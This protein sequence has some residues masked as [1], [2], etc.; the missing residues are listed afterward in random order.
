MGYVSTTPSQ[1]RDAC[2]QS[3]KRCRQ[4]VDSDETPKVTNHEQSESISE[5]HQTLHVETR[6]CECQTEGLNW[7]G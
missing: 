7:M 2:A 4:D 1:E 5:M 3:R 6:D